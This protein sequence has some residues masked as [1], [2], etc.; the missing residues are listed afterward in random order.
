MA[1]HLVPDLVNP[2]PDWIARP[3]SCSPGG[4]RMIPQLAVAQRFKP[5]CNTYSA[6]P[7]DSQDVAFHQ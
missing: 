6:G 4:E 7:L 3:A 5:F 2:I 1:V